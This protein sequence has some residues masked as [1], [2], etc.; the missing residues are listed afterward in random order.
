MDSSIG[1]QYLMKQ[2]NPY[3]DRVKATG[4]LMPN[5]GY[6][7]PLL[8]YM[9]GKDKA[10]GE[11]WDT[12]RNAA[13]ENASQQGMLQLKN[14]QDQEYATKIL[15]NIIEISKHDAPAATALLKAEAQKNPHLQ[16]YKDITFSSETKDEWATVTTSEGSY[17]V[18]LPGL[19]EISDDPNSEELR[20]KYI[21]PVGGKKVESPYKGGS[22]QEFIHPKLG[23]VEGTYMGLDESGKP[24]WEDIVKVP[25][26]GAN[27]ND[28]ISAFRQ[29]K[30]QLDGLYKAKASV[31]KGYDPYTGE[32]IPQTQIATALKTIDDQI[33]R[34]ERYMKAKFPDEW[35][36]YGGADKLPDS[37]SS[38]TTPIENSIFPWEKEYGSPSTQTRQGGTMKKEDMSKEIMPSMPPASKHPGRV[39]K[40]TVTGKRYRSN[41]REWS[42]VR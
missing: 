38:N 17:Q 22:R 41:G 5:S 29:Y 10:A 28:T 39:I 21:I 33:I 36:I 23:K 8:G 4:A 24:R 6:A 20:K 30:S 26:Q 13:L 40:D 18:Y 35:G 2:N 32:L 42:E 16:P 3:D 7:A 27:P 14:Q 12:N 9:M 37:T 31:Q 34:A 19:K 1:L 11:R 15:G 25:E